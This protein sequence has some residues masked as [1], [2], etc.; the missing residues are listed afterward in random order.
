MTWKDLRLRAI[1]TS[2]VELSAQRRRQARE[3]EV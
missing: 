3:A 1:N 2:P